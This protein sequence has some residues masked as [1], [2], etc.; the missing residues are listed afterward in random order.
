[1]RL[2]TPQTASVLRT[3]RQ[4]STFTAISA[5]LGCTEAEPDTRRSAEQLT[6]QTSALRAS[7]P[8]DG[9]LFGYSVAIAD[10]AAFVGALGHQHGALAGAVYAFRL[11]ETGWRQD[12][13]E[14]QP[15]DG[16]GNGDFGTSVSASGQRVAVGSQSLG[17]ALGGTWVFERAGAGWQQSGNKLEAFEGDV[18]YVPTPADGFGFAVALDGDD[19]LVGAPFANV[20]SH[21]EDCGAVFYF[22]REG[23]VWLGKQVL[24]PT[25]PA[26]GGEFGGA[27]AIH[28]DSAAVGAS[29]DETVAPLAG[30]AYYF[31]RE[32]GI[33]VQKQKLTGEDAESSDTNL[34]GASFGWSVAVSEQALLV[35]APFEML[36]SQQG[37]AVVFHRSDPDQLFEFGLKH[38]L[39]SDENAGNE[40]VGYAVAVSDSH[41]L[42]GS[43]TA[44]SGGPFHSGQV[45]ILDRAVDWDLEFTLYPPAVS[46]KT[47]F[48]GSLAVRGQQAIVGASEDDE[49]RG[50][51]FIGALA[52]SSPCSDNLDCHTGFCVENVCCDTACEGACVS[53]LAESKQ[54]GATGKCGPIEAGARPKKDDGCAVNPTEFCGLTG[55]CDGAGSCAVRPK[56]TSCGMGTCDGKTAVPEPT[57]DG[58]E[59]C[60]PAKTKVCAPGYD[61]RKGDC[62]QECESDEQCDLANGFACIEGA[63]GVV[64]GGQCEQ[65]ADC[66]ADAQCSRGTC[67]SDECDGPCQRCDSNGACRNAPDGPSPDCAEGDVCLEGTCAPETWCS[68]DTRRE[69]HADGTERDCP[70][71]T[72]CVRG[73]CAERC[74]RGSEDCEPGYTC[75]KEDLMCVVDRPQSQGSPT[76]V[77]TTHIPGPS[78]WQYLICFGLAAAAWCSRRQ[79]RRRNSP[80]QGNVTE[81]PFDGIH[82]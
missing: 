60:V 28:G 58:Q 10:G 48:G 50:S 70:A 20:A 43:P 23:G 19:L 22:H 53:C 5:L 17:T 36:D 40:Q 37:S 47:F 51:A 49:H 54:G 67:C 52:S 46:P 38:L 13:D 33:W 6:W 26:A 24:Y 21:C 11:T 45:A 76:L 8:S 42:V 77:C 15:L 66:L 81:S 7:D 56:G 9:D 31:A 72:R 30:A 18:G 64:L 41:A 75:R 78:K 82:T 71:H 32:G 27:V 57:C 73:R 62:S 2:P 3:F 65:D 35:G 63:C 34:T 14:L 80:P 61:C 25:D 39:D 68:D 16:E 29:R 74:T 1:M 79:A 44:P 4:V 55:V 59:N 12:P 69:L